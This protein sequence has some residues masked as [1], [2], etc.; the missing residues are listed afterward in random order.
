[1]SELSFEQ[2]LEE[3]FK[4]IRN[5]EVVEGTVIDV[6]PDEIILNIGYK[7]DGILTKSEYTNEPNLDLT[8]VA[9]PGD[10]MEVKVLK[11]NDGEGQVLLTYKRLAAEKG[12]KRLEEAFESQEVLTAKVAQVLNGGLSVVVD[13]ARVFIPASLVSDSYE[14]DLS[15]YADTD[16][17]FVISEFNPRR[18]RVIG[19]RKQLLVAAKAEQQKALF[20]RI[21]EGDI[22]EGTIKNVTDFGAFIDLGGA[23]GLLH[24]SEMSWGR[25]D[26]PKKV[27]KAGEPITVLIKEIN[28]NKIALSLKFHDQNPWLTAAENYAVGNVVEGKIARMTD[29]GAFVELEPGVDALL[30]VS[31]I[32]RDH[33]EK[34]ADVLSIGQMITA[35]VVDFNGEEK[36]ISLSMKVLESEVVE[37]YVEEPV[38]EEEVYNDIPVEE[39]TSEAEAAETVNSDDAINFEEA[40]AVEMDLEAAEVDT[41]NV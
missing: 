37:E 4:T 10:K 21:T 1:M 39:I 15:K 41:E 36:K 32:S 14:K 29:F 16:I 20:E 5:G 24:I 19:D 25:V 13:E 33:V 34:P 31:Q 23:D 30:H 8:T 38:Y 40:E 17:E 9:K 35:S 3:S 6:K 18:R 7:A 2:M 26:N 12:N 27:F 28:G 22:V 11:V